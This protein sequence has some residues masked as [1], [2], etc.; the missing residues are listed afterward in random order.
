MFFFFSFLLPQIVLCAS[1]QRKIDGSG[2]E[3][4]LCSTNNLCIPILNISQS[5]NLVQFNAISSKAIKDEKYEYLGR[6]FS[7]LIFLLCVSVILLYVCW[8]T[9]T[10]SKKTQENVLNLMPKL[11]N[12]L[13]A[14]VHENHITNTEIKESLQNHIGQYQKQKFIEK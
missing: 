7:V 11:L 5:I 6:L 8:E 13:R 3:W 9:M 14:Q 2:E 12:Q 10:K 4:K 1:S